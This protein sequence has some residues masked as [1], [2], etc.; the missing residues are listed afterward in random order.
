MT[1]DD[2]AS[3][4]RRLPL[5]GV[6]ILA[7]AI[8]WA[9]PFGS[10]ILADLGADVIEIE[11]IQ[12]MSMTRGQMRH[13]P[14]QLLD[15]PNGASLYNRD[16]SEG[17]WNRGATFNFAKRGH[18]SVTIDLNREAGRELFYGLIRE[19]DVFM[20]NNAADVV[21]NLQI[22]WPRLS[23]LNP[24]LIMVRFPG[25]GIDG[26]YRDFK[27]FGATM[28]AIV[29]HSYLRGYR[30][31]DP[32]ATPSIYHGDPNAGATAA[33][34]IQ[35]ALFARERTGKGQLIDLSQAEAVIHHTSYSLMDYLINQRVHQPWGNRHPWMAP[36]G[37]FPC[38]GESRWLALAIDSD[39]AFTALC[40]EMGQPA[41]AT[42]TRFATAVERYA[43]Q[44]PLEELIAAWTAEH[45]D[46]DLM[47]RLQAVGVIA[48]MVYPQPELFDDPHLQARGYFMELE[49]PE[50]PRRRYPAPMAQFEELPLLPVR[51]PAPTLGQHNREILQGILGLSDEQYEAALQQQLVGTAYLEDVK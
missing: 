31:S 9:G 3:A 5:Q 23:E 51:G 48:A 29:G 4:P 13:I 2:T 17:F 43:N 35:A 36:Y 11:S 8:V 7:Q 27:G 37:V 21:G 6:R 1:N 50:V 32:S 40:A 10:M 46:R 24:R 18:R 38:R 22:D 14:Q 15:G 34:A 47:H 44:D 19:A 26:P 49:Y 42:D 41:L 33:F 16:G 25:F 20:E 39:E 12:H 30:D 45:E 28:E